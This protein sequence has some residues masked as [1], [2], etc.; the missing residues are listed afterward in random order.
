MASYRTTRFVDETEGDD[1]DVPLLESRLIRLITTTQPKRP[2][3]YRERNT[4][5]PIRKYKPRVARE[6]MY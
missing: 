4:E 2:L 1:D 6:H 3:R 5:K